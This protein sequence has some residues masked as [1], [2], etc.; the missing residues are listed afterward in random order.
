MRRDGTVA[1]HQLED[2]EQID[3]VMFGAPSINFCIVVVGFT[4]I[5]TTGCKGRFFD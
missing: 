5:S 1:D 4:I 3:V 2:G